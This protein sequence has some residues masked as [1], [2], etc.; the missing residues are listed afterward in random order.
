MKKKL[1]PEMR[2]RLQEEH[3]KELEQKKHH[4]KINHPGSKDQLEEVWE[5]QDHLEP[6]QFNPKT[7]FEL[8]DIDN[9]KFLDQNE[10]EAIFATE[11]H[12]A[13]NTLI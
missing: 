10:L 6:N 1:D 3:D 5:K 13:N 4:E 2:K 12:K 11:V 7:F 8:H 9:N